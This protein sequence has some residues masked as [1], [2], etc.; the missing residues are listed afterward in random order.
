MAKI[1]L[2]GDE[3]IKDL[4][5]GVNKTADIVGKTLG[6]KGKNIILIY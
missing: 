2:G 6:P 3:L 5:S 4:V 1:N